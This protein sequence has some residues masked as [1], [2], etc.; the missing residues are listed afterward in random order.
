MVNLKNN[1]EGNIWREPRAVISFII[2]KQILLHFYCHGDRCYNRYIE[3]KKRQNNNLDN[4]DTG[5]KPEHF[6]QILMRYTSGYDP[7]QQ[8]WDRYRK[9]ARDIFGKKRKSNGYIY[10]HGSKFCEARGHFAMRSC[11]QYDVNNSA[12][13]ILKYIYNL[14]F[15]IQCPPR[16][17]KDTKMT[18]IENNS[19]VKSPMKVTP[20]ARIKR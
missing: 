5:V 18:E 17:V 20:V 6:L 1:H 11:L 12:P 9:I 3:R 7:I 8:I 4:D 14:K 10:L 16:R 13:R 2:K 15:Y 19:Y